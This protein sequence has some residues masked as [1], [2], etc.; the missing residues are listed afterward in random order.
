MKIM[1]SGGGTLGPVAPLLAIKEIYARRYPE[2]EFAWVGT[3]N[4]PE[5]ELVQ[6]YKIPFLTITSGKLRRYF[7]FLNIADLFKIVVGFFE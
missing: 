4:G 1:F 7:S 6:A 2:A 3:K 5:K